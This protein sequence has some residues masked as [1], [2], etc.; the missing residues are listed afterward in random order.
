MASH[1]T[2]TSVAISIAC[3][4]VVAVLSTPA[5]GQL[6]TRVQSRKKQD[7]HLSERYE[8]KDGVATQ[9]SE[10]SY[11][12]QI[13]RLILILI[14][15]VAC[16]VALATAILTTA[17]SQLP[18]SLEQWLQFATW[19]LV[20]SQAA[21][22]YVTPSSTQRY[23]LG[24]FSSFSA[25]SI[26]IAVAVENISLWQ[27]ES[28]PLPRNIH[29]TFSIILFAAGIGLAVSSLCIPRRPDVY[30]NDKIV[31]RENTVSLL[32][33][34]TFSWAAPILSFA[35]K[36]KGLDYDDLHEI[37]FEN[38]SRE[39]RREFEA[40]GRKDKLWKTIFWSRK[41]TFIQQWI[42]Q[43]TCSI[44][45]FLPQ[46]V[47]YFVLK[48]LE[49]R[50]EG[51]DVALTSWLLVIGL[52]LA[53]TFSN[54][55]EAWMFFITFMKIGVP[56]YE[57]LSAVV[58][59]KAIRR[60][61]VKGTGKKQ[62][63]AETGDGALN[64]GTVVNEAAGQKGEDRVPE[65][66]EDADFQKSKQSTINLV[67]VDSK[68]IADFATFNYIFL[69]SAI[70]LIFA[71]SFL[72]KLIGPIPL[73]AGLAAPVLI[74]PINILAAKRYATA[75]DDLMKY[76]DQKMAVVTEALQGIRQIKFSALERNWYDKILETR[77]RELKTQWQVFVYDTT[78]ISIWIFGPVMLAAIS[79]TTYVLIY[80]QLTA[81]VAF[82]TISVFEAI[83]MTLAIIPEM[84]TD[85]LDAIVSAKRVQ[86]Y[87]DAP[88]R[89]ESTRPGE[90]VSF[91]NT[92]IAWPSDD[93]ANED[94]QFT[95]RS[96]DLAFPQKELSVISGRTG[97]GKSLLLASIIGEADVLDGELVV[98]KPPS[99]AQRYDAQANRKNWTIDSSIAFVAQI[100]WIENAT[101]RDNILFGLPL[102]NDRY[103]KVLT[104]CALTKD[105]EMLQDGELTDIG[106]NGINLSGGQKWRVS[107]ARA[108]Y[109][110]AG[111]LVLDDIFSAV[112]AH[113]GRHL[114]EQALTGELGQGR[115][116]I[117]VTHHVA[118]CLP[119]TNYSVLLSNG[120]VEV[121]GRTE[122][123]RRSGKLKS[124]LAQDIEEQQKE[125]DE[126]IANQQN[127]NLAVDDG[128]GLQKLL[129]NQSRRSRR[130]SALSDAGDDLRRRPSHASMNEAK[131]NGNPP[132][133]FTEDESRETGA[134]KYRI[135]AAYIRACGGFTYWL[136]ILAIF[137]V[138]VA[139]YLARSYWISVW[140]RSYRTESDHAFQHSLLQQA[141]GSAYHRLHYRLSTAAIDPNLRYYLG[142]YLGISLVAWLIGTVRY[143]C[144]FVL[145]IRASKILFERLAFAILR[146]PLRWLDTVPVGR[147]LNRF[148]SDFNMLDSR[149]SMDLAFML[150]NMMHVLSVVIAGLFV[151]PFM[152]VFAAALLSI[153]MYYA[154]RYLAGA[155]EVKRL[156]SNAKSPVFEQFGSVLMG[157]GTIRAFDKCDA[158]LD[159][160]YARIDL[161]CR[162]YW[163]LWLFNRWMGWRLNMVGAIFAAITAALI[164]SIT[165]IDS[166]LAGFALSFALGLSEGV[167]WFLR[168]YSNVELDMN[169]T[170]RIVEYSNITIENQ[171][172]VDAPAAW[173]TEGNLEVNDLVVSYAPDLPPVLR[174]LTFSVARNQRVGVV[175][176]TG[177]GKSSLT[178]ALFRFLEARSGSIHIDGV[179][180]S[181]IKLYDLR[182][183][184]AIIPQDPVLFSGTVR[185]NLD[186]FDQQTDEELREALARVHLISSASLATSGAASGS[187][188]PLPPSL[189]GAAPAQDAPRD[190]NRNIFRSLSSKISEG[191]LNLSQGQRQL[192]CLARAIVSRPKIMVLDEATSAVDMETDALIQ[193]SIRE[194]FTD[195]TLIVIAHRLSTIAD[196]DRI[197]VLGEGKV[198]EYDS[199]AALMRRE[200]GAF[201]EM[202]EMSGERGELE[203]VIG[204]GTQEGEGSD[205]GKA[206][207]SKS[208]SGGG[209]QEA[210]E[211]GWGI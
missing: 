196:F 207:G 44:T 174:G 194:E 84:I 145:S 7:A 109:S 154:L 95:L 71:I 124:I 102:D 147:I 184:L 9:E 141:L 210:D 122:E 123:L 40:V 193:R 166:S 148:T 118:L 111:I 150:H 13:P 64:G 14:S 20:L 172:G 92:T 1:H 105:L 30:W 171:G 170:E 175:G 78:L 129:T 34:L 126:A 79:L 113:V 8:D 167:I 63:E 103:Q 130:K 142:V 16:G 107:F 93:P 173:P 177:A 31:D 82:T 10:Q 61:D 99:S 189:R 127:Q 181:K 11:S 86:E 155:R 156:E 158:Y 87:L 19:L 33:K 36:N 106:A 91:K 94:N 48:T 157:I 3:L 101:I 100:P 88:E 39:L 27:A 28:S 51:K 54:W 191:G 159:K 72:S 163:H 169:A 55:I 139:V 23:R 108:L 182:S 152:I 15:L 146:A 125:E 25:L 132:K 21:I 96:L 178:L 76:R 204:I 162:A 98:P 203:R 52:G 180:I 81:S 198:L 195:S 200:A 18:L 185:S 176:R 47:L 128:G 110:R 164:V 137:G 115:T 69:G 179:D 5:V 133:K 74:T 183:R 4:A 186:P 60:K 211:R 190:T 209:G 62:A 143:F 17:R 59:G 42:L 121:E 117:L 26:A 151:S 119:R 68:R 199:P 80:K 67:G 135:Y 140:T 160:M 206:N 22:I 90:A 114:F 97:S 144:V 208:A 70:K 197:L 6:F 24:V 2:S 187:A 12:D 149:I 53:I 66:D 46:I 56:I 43:A 192:L 65:E 45:D 134:I 35:A 77:R 73:L 153:S 138:W 120:T 29:L 104:A 83:E 165:T 112:D 168:Q 205:K 89:I 49:Q 202:V 32:S 188:T 41:W 37:D 131:P 58:F 85:L 136:G 75:Q 201:K 50:D 38:R 161:H 116:R 57:Q